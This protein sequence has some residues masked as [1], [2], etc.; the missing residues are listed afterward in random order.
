MDTFERTMSAIADNTNHDECNDPKDCNGDGH[1]GDGG[2]EGGTNQRSR[3][4]RNS[5]RDDDD[6]GGYDQIY[7]LSLSAPGAHGVCH[8][9]KP[10]N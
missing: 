9:R 3:R 10:A 5:G 6:G 7:Y 4:R 1:G 2:G 8:L